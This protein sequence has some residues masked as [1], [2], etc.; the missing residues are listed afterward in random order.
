MFFYIYIMQKLYRCQYWSLQASM[1]INFWQFRTLNYFKGDI[2]EQSLQWCYVGTITI[3]DVQRQRLISA[4]PIVIYI[5]SF[6]AQGVSLFSMTMITRVKEVS[7]FGRW[8]FSYQWINWTIY[9]MN[10]PSHVNLMTEEYIY[11]DLS[12][13]IVKIWRI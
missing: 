12:T 13:I 1:F 11:L 6:L 8:V 3:V 4:L 5:M 10:L 9:K 7:Y 2:L